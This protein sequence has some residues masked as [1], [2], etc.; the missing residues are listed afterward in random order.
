MTVGLLSLLLTIVS[1]GPRVADGQ[2]PNK[3]FELLK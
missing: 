2:N 1:L 3:Y